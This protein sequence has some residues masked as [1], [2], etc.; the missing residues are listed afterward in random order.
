MYVEKEFTEIKVW[1]LERLKIDHSSDLN[2]YIN[3]W[4]VV[5]FPRFICDVT[6]ESTESVEH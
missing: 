2:I 6:C 4:A 1:F 3:K 5:G